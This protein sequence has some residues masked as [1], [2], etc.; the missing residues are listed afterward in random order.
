MNRLFRI[1]TAAAALGL[2]LVLTAAPLTARA[3]L[4]QQQM[5]E[6]AK[7]AVVF[8]EYFYKGWVYFNGQKYGS[9]RDPGQ[10]FFES[11]FG[12]IQAG[13]FVEGA[14]ASGFLVHPDG[15]I[16]T[17]GHCV[18]DYTEEGQMLL[19]YAF[20]RDYRI[21]V[22]IQQTGRQPTQQEL[23]NM[24]QQLLASGAQVAELQKEIYVRTGNAAAYKADVLVVSE[25]EGGKD[26]AVIK[27]PG[28]NFP[29]IPIGNSDS[30]KEGDDVFIIGF[31]GIMQD[32]TTGRALSVVSL[33][34]PTVTKGIVSALQID[35]KG[36]PVIQVDA[37]SAGGNSGGPLVN[38]RGEAIGICS[39]GAGKVSHEEGG[40]YNMFVPMAQARVF[41]NQSGFAPESGL[42]DEV[43]RRALEFF[44][45]GNY[46]KALPEFKTVLEFYPRHPRAQEY[47]L[48]C[49]EKIESGEGGGGGFPAWLKWLL[50]ILVA[51]AVV[52]LVVWL[53]TRSGAAAPAKKKGTPHLVVE[54]G[55]LAGN[56][57]PIEKG[58]LL[59]G[60]DP[61]RCQVVLTGETVSREHAAIEPGPGGSLRV[62][63]LSATNPTCINDRSITEAE[64]K[65]GDRLRVGKTIFVLRFE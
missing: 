27:I 49:N 43:Y 11:F 42:T 24:F 57:F 54:S 47:I 39:W 36:V 25:F 5:L 52:A 6:V 55:S 8:V 14:G 28:K 59:I 58:G 3:Q 4:S 1:K 37:T 21:P 34:N 62:R 35:V 50:I 38:T 51:A 40:S 15:Y 63:N 48:Q 19:L 46:T 16:L 32:M 10:P 29:T 2:V 41:I 12:T 65:S 9:M 33:F 18:Q 7:P 13:P 30:V 60:R 26:V 56:R 61:A 22:F 45:K 23:Q 53:L 64:I 17:A 20:L 44:W 31:P